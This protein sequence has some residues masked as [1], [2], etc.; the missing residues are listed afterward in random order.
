MG[1]ENGGPY[2]MLSMQTALSD[3]RFII[4]KTKRLKKNTHMRHDASQYPDLIHVL[5]T[6]EPGL[7][8]DLS[9]DGVR[10]VKWQKHRALPCGVRCCLL[11]GGTKAFES[12]SS[13]GRLAAIKGSRV[14]QSP[15]QNRAVLL[16]GY[17]SLLSTQSFTRATTRADSSSR[18]PEPNGHEKSLPLT[19]HIL[20]QSGTRKPLRNEPVL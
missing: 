11:A 16:T 2:K 7:V 12:S 18:L 4:R 15:E 5:F 14:F 10:G 1:L 3:C 13:G 8:G 6:E 17:D 20:I 9:V 19:T